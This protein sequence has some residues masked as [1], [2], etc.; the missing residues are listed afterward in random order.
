MLKAY[1]N[2]C[3]AQVCCPSRGCVV[4]F[5]KNIFEMVYG[6]LLV[7]QLPAGQ[8]LAGHLLVQHVFAI[9]NSVG[10]GESAWQ[11]VMMRV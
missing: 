8:M 9:N 11:S 10:E 7:G 3:K 2:F 5:Y 1:L 4:N 6:H